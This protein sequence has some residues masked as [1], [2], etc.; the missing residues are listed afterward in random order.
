MSSG[1][2]R[3]G[4]S[5]ASRKSGMRTTMK[6]MTIPNTV[7][8]RPSEARS[9]PPNWTGSSPRNPCAHGRNDPMIMMIAPAAV[10]SRSGL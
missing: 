9:K 2:Q 3:L 5:G 1:A 7:R 4:P 6:R 8:I 10:S